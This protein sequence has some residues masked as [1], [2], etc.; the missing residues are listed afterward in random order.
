VMASLRASFTKDGILKARKIEDRLTDET[1]ASAKGYDLLP[2]LTAVRVPAIVISGDHDFI[3]A[4]TASHIARA[5][6]G[7]RLV[8]LRDCG[9]F[10][11]LE[12]PGAVRKELDEFF[13]QGK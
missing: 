13:R 5:I 6:P 12:C 8:T 10:S 1:W 9:H 7:A 4:D 2:K 11:Y 3:P